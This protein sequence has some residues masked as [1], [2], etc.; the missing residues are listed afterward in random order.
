M[1]RLCLSDGEQSFDVALFEA[2]APS[3]TVLFA[4]GSGGNPEWH[5]P[6]LAS[7]CERGCSVVAPYL[8]QLVTPMPSEAD[9]MMRARRLRL[10]L[11]Q[12]A[13]PQLPSTGIGHSIGATVLLA[14]AGAQVWMPSRTKLAVA[15]DPRLKRLVLM[16]PPTGFFPAPAVLKAVSVPI[17]LWTAGKDVITPPTQA[18]Y[19]RQALADRVAVDFHLVEDADHFSFMNVRPPETSEVLPDRESFL[20]QLAATVAGFVAH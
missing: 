13:Q 3:A 18:E 5:L 10:A 16:A 2:V 17:Q 12:I 20:A 19:L 1:R 11:D 8:E 7:L 4:V 14:L 6:L 9:L 15:P